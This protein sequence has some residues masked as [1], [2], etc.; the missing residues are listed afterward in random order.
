MKKFIELM[1]S[2]PKLVQLA[3]YIGPINIVPCDNKMFRSVNGHTYCDNHS[4]MNQCTLFHLSFL[5][6]KLGMT[7][8]QKVQV[9]SIEKYASAVKRN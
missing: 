6:N 1:K 7:C 5:N 9:R 8:T 2:S 3:N 4:S